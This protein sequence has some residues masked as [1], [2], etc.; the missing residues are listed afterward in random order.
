MEGAAVVADGV[1]TDPGDLTA[2][3]VECGRQRY[4]GAVIEGHL[5][6]GT[7]GLAGRVSTVIDQDRAAV[8]IIDLDVHQGNGTA[9]IF[10]DD[11]TVFT[12]STIARQRA[13]RVA[14]HT[15]EEL[16]PRG[17][18]SVFGVQRAV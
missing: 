4:V 17:R 18:G 2:A 7:D 9:A 1:A 3:L 13:S 12:F 8:G 5:F 15:I 16:F 6:D 11:P 10:R 14:G